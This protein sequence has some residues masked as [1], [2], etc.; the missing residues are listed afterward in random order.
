MI[1]HQDENANRRMK[2]NYHI[3][4]ITSLTEFIGQGNQA[5]IEARIAWHKIQLRKEGIFAI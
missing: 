2:M 3:K 4:M 5:A 1:V